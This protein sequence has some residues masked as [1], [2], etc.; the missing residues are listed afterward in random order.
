MYA[1]FA[2]IADDEMENVDEGD[3][4]DV[5]KTTVVIIKVIQKLKKYFGLDKN[6]ISGEVTGAPSG[7]FKQSLATKIIGSVVK[8]DLN[9]DLSGI[10][11]SSADNDTFLSTDDFNITSGV[12]PKGECWETGVGQE[13]AKL[14]VF[15]MYTVVLSILVFG[16]SSQKQTTV[17]LY[18]LY[19]MYHNLRF[20][21][22]DEL[23]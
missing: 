12:R 1:L 18:F 22:Y 17:A 4:C 16:N 9:S 10:D 7:D 21:S 13:L 5:A 14:I 3:P 2:R 23:T 15:D 6:V 20:I 11:S 8:R 19:Y